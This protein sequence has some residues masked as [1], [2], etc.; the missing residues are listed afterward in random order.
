MSQKFAV[1]DIDGTVLRWQFYHAIVH[2]LSNSGALG[3]ELSKKIR[4]ARFTWKQRAHTDSFHDYE[5]T[6]VQ[7]YREARINI[8]GEA[9]DAAV[10]KVF[11]TYKNQVYTYTRDLIKQLKSEG[12][13]LLA[14]SGSQQEVVEKFGA[15]YG[16]DAVVGSKYARTENGT[17]GQRISS[18]VKDGGKGPVLQQLINDHGLIQK[19]SYA[20]GDSASDAAM[21]ELVEHPIAFNPD[22]ALFEIAKKHGWKVVIERKNMTYELEAQ[23]GEYRLV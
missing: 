19:D 21:L 6:L 23:D 16:F 8:S 1:F 17:L 14:V 11:D 20:V 7:A 18:P 13:F 15:Y 3:D 9:F 12:Y 10:N 4:D 22:K 2:E 5:Q